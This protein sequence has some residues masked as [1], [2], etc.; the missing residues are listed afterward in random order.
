MADNDNIGGAAYGFDNIDSSDSASDGD[1][2]NSGGGGGSREYNNG[3]GHDFG[4]F[5]FCERDNQPHATT[6]VPPADNEPRDAPPIQT[7]SVAESL[8]QVQHIDYVVVTNPT[9]DEVEP[10]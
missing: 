4:V 10:F 3:G 1:N 2:S 7:F 8:R 6:F 5:N 9:T